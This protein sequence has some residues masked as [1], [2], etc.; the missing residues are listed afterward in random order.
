[1]FY[2]HTD[3]YARDYRG[4]PPTPPPPGPYSVPPP[5][6][7]YGRAPYGHPKDV[8]DLQFDSA[9]DVS[10]PRPVYRRQHADSYDRHPYYTADKEPPPPPRETFPYESGARRDAPSDP[11]MYYPS[12]RHR[13][14]TPSHHEYDRRFEGESPQAG[15]LRDDRRFEA[16]SSQAG[17][18]RDD[19]PFPPHRPQGAV[20][21]H[22]TRYYPDPRG[23]SAHV[24]KS[25]GLREAAL[26]IRIPIGHGQGML[27]HGDF[28]RDQERA[29]LGVVEKQERERAEKVC[30]FHGFVLS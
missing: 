19:M 25:D 22:P 15:H 9:Q 21:P 26:D 18:L 14:P 27:G 29:G 4:Y 7:Q 28:D 11:P 16:E 3:H 23:G 8:A 6:Y 5:P 12:I 1:M 2:C 24:D 20:S 30:S 10:P 13:Y 17:H